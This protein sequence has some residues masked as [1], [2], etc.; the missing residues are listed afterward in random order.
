MIRTDLDYAMHLDSRD[1]LAQLRDEFVIEDPALIY[2]NE[3]RC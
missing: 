1:E 2:R 3:A